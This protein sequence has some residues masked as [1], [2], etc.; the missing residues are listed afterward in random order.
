[1]LNSQI[2]G[3]FLAISAVFAAF[4]LT[5]CERE[6]AAFA[7]DGRSTVSFV[8][9]STRTRA[10]VTPHE[11]A[12]TSLD[13]LVFRSVEG[14]LDN[15]ARVASVNGEEVRSISVELTDGASLDWYVVANAPE[16]A[17]SFTSK[18]AFLEALTL[19]TQST[20]RSLV[21]HGSGR[22]PSGP[23]EEPVRVALDRYSCKV[24]V[25][26]V[27][28]DWP[29]AFTMASSVA[30]G[31]IVLVNVVGST[32]WSGV[33]AAGEPWYNRMD[34]ESG[35]PAVVE[36]MT[37]KDYGGAALSPG[38]AYDADSPLYCMPNPTA[39]NV[40]SLNTPQWSPR[41]TRVA[42]EILL[43]GVPNWYPVDLPAMQCNHHYLINSLTVKGPGSAGPDYP[44]E[45]EDIRFTVTVLPWDETT[46]PVS[47]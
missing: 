18:A 4:S 31:R 28:V 35:L 2:K 33:P 9:G 13:V 41:D 3:A 40:N 16:G 6:P 5:S 24:T 47:Y 11:G 22:L 19:L 29:E 15:A 36:D 10:A 26:S 20:D 32:P 7:G 46:I 42:V 39:N 37:V 43:D 44:V 8:L 30:L 34:V 12:V 27:I 1:M 17:L 25:S 38:V 14:T 45:R 23:T 21:M